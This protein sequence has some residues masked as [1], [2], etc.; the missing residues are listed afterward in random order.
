MFFSKVGDVPN[1]IFD[2][3]ILTNNYAQGKFYQSNISPREFYPS[4]ISPSKILSKKL[5]SKQKLDYVKYAK[6]LQI[7]LFSL[8]YA[9]L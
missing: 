8:I 5:L 7:M 6:I 2:T 4:D 1:I 9:V 3:T